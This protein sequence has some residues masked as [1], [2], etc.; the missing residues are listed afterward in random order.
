[1]L[2]L[3]RRVAVPLALLSTL[4]HAKTQRLPLF[5][6]LLPLRK[7]LPCGSLAL[8]KRCRNFRLSFAVGRKL[9]P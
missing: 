6:A 1:M 5:L 9:N 8:R 2:H 3:A 4:H 7:D